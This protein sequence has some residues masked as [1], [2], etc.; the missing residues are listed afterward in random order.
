M[1]FSWFSDV[2]LY[3][4]NYS[5]KLMYMRI[6]RT[7]CMRRLKLYAL[8][9]VSTYISRA[10][11]ENIRKMAKTEIQKSKFMRE[12]IYHL[13]G[14]EILNKNCILF[15]ISTYVSRVNG[16]NVC[17]KRKTEISKC[18]FMRQVIYNLVGH[19]ILNKTLYP[20]KRYYFQILRCLR[21]CMK[22]LNI[23]ESNELKY[24]FIKYF[25]Q[26]LTQ[27]LYVTYLYYCS[28]LDRQR[29]I[30]NKA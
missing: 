26:Y 30:E 12:M 5:I 8:F 25:A 18:K 9:V 15:V 13:V 16:E 29:K 3:L 17:K 23:I 21:K 1:D 10:I 7:G 4:T 2:P 27:V 19:K 24:S 20:F 6:I 28:V 22:K 11:N 14:H